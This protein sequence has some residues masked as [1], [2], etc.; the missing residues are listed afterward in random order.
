MSLPE[1]WCDVA[2][3]DSPRGYTGLEGISI[4]DVLVPGT[5]RRQV[6][7]WA[8]PPQRPVRAQ[9]QVAVSPQGDAADLAVPQAVGLLRWAV[10]AARFEAAIDVGNARAFGVTCSELDL[11][12]VNFQT[13]APGNEIRVCASITPGVD[14]PVRPC[15]STSISVPGGG[16][17]ADLVIPAFAADLEL[18]TDAAAPL[19][20]SW[21]GSKA[22]IVAWTLDPTLAVPQLHR[23][24]NGA[25]VLRITNAGVPAVDVLA[26]SHLSI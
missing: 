17:V 11:T 2:T 7:R 5:D 4:G 3:S 8:G 22:A 15:V 24:P 19:A 21:R 18:Y 14:V 13:A 23:V 16:G 6:L 12:V 1:R 20:V 26:V 10:G 9:V 25:S